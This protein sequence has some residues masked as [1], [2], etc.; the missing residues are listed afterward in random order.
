MIYLIL[1]IVFAIF[2]LWKVSSSFDLAANYLTRDI[3]EGIKGPTINAIASSLPELFISFLF[4]FYYGDIKGFSAGY[5]TI[6]GSSAFNIAVIPVVSFLVV[7]FRKKTQHFEVDR[8]ILRQ[9]GL[10]LLGAVLL[11]LGGLYYGINKYFAVVLIVYYILYIRSL[12]I[13]RKDNETGAEKNNIVRIE[14]STGILLDI[15]N[16]RLFRVFTAG[17]VNSITSIFVIIASIAIIAYSCHLLITS[18]EE[19]SRYIGVNLF[20]VSFIIASIA[21]SLP[22]TFLS[23][24]DAINGKFNDSFSNAYGSNM[25]DICIGLGLPLLIYT[26]LHGPIDTT[27]AIKRIGSLGDSILNGNVLIWSILL[28]LILTTVTSLIYYCKQLRFRYAVL[29]L[30][31]YLLFMFGLIIF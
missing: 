16:I 14:P 8:N 17:K 6:I 1:K 19:I 23:V 3:G 28:L 18:T 11:F 10:F 15:L 7:F 9:D 26:Y 20:F 13:S 22:D 30:L 5:A 24:K 31:L 2:I 21:S 4:L 12:Y 27:F 25:F 29:I